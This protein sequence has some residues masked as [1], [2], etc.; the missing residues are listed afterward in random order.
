MTCNYVVGYSNA[1]DHLEYF[2]DICMVWPFALQANGPVAGR[3]GKLAYRFYRILLP[4]AGQSAGIKRRDR[5]RA[6]KNHSG[7]HHPVGLLRIFNFVPA[8]TAEMELPGGLPLH[9]RRRVVRVCALAAIAKELSVLNQ[10]AFRSRNRLLNQ[11]K[12]KPRSKITSAPAATPGLYEAAL[13][14]RKAQ[15]TQNNMVGMG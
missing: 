8:R 9:R 15:T 12:G 1:V 10:L 14:I 4:G 3:A 13:W 11:Y 7:S 5:H 6:T 2:H